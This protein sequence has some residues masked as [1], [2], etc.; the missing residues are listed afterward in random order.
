MA[1]A[2]PSILPSWDRLVVE[3]CTEQPLMTSVLTL[4]LLQSGMVEPLEVFVPGL[5]RVTD[6]LKKDKGISLTSL[7]TAPER[8]GTDLLPSQSECFQI[9][10]PESDS[11]GSIWQ[12]V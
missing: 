5:M 1:S 9:R 10:R 3:G 11:A 2:M 8:K 6:C 4:S 7:Q 12:S